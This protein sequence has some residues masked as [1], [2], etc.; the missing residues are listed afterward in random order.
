MVLSLLSLLFG[1]GL[2]D[3]ARSVNDAGRRAGLALGRAKDVVRGV[4]EPVVEV[5]ERGASGE[6]LR[7]DAEDRPPRARIDDDSEPMEEALAEDEA[8]EAARRRHRG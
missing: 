2:R 3:A 5:R 4:G 8:A 1:R 6:K 7:V